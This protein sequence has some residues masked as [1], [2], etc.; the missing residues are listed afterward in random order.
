MGKRVSEESG[1]TFRTAASV[2][3]LYTQFF[4]SPGFYFPPKSGASLW[5]SRC[6]LGLCSALLMHPHPNNHTEK[7]FSSLEEKKVQLQ[8]FS[9]N[10]TCISTR[11]TSALCPGL[12]ACRGFRACRD[13]F[14]NTETTVVI[15]QAGQSLFRSFWLTCG[16]HPRSCLWSQTEICWQMNNS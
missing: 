16:T 10:Y 5:D 3:K 13:R 11:V 2:I 8:N 15:S 9:K 6:K 4:R 12:P 1:N 14:V 7:I